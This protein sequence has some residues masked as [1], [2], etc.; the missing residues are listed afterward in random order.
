MVSNPTQLIPACNWSKR[1]SLFF[2]RW[3]GAPI[4]LSGIRFPYARLTS[5]VSRC[6]YPLNNV[7]VCSIYKCLQSSC[8]GNGSCCTILVNIECS[9]VDESASV[10]FDRPCLACVPDACQRSVSVFVFVRRAAKLRLHHLFLSR[11][12][13]RWCVVFWIACEPSTSQCSGDL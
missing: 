6:F 7:I 12:W 10:V 5:H 1:S 4:L 8:S 9:C 2:S 11:V 13:E 3:D